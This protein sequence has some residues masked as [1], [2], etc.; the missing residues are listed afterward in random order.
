MIRRMESSQ[1]IPVVLEVNQ[2]IMTKNGWE[3][4]LEKPEDQESRNIRF[5]LVMGFETEM[6]L[7]DTDELD[8]YVMSV[9]TDGALMEIM[10]AAGWKWS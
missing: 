7:V 9:A 4:Y 6:G 10:P 8:P 5:G 3:Y 1:T 2:H